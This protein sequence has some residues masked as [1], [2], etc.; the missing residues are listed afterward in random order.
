MAI[1]TC[2][3]NYQTAPI[4]IREQLAFNQDNIIVPLR[5]LI[6]R[7]YAR[8]AA[9]LSTCNRTEF[10]CDIDNALPIKEW[11]NQYSDIELNPYLY[12]YEERAAVRHILRVASGLDSMI[13]GEPQI[14]GQMKQA[15]AIAREAGTLGISLKRL[16]QHI[17]N[18][19]K[20]V[21]TNTAIGINSVSIASSAVNLSKRIFADLSKVTALLIGAGDTTSLAARYLYNQKIKH[22]II[23]NRTL[24]N[25]KALAEQFQGEAI[26][27]GDIPKYLVNADIIITATAS[28]LPIL[29]KGAIETALKVRKHRPMFM[30]DLA[31]PRDIEPEVANLKD[32]YLYTVDDLQNFVNDN[33]ENR[34]KAAEQAEQII[35][36]QA[37][38]YIRSLNLLDSVATICAFRENY[39]KIAQD[40]LQKVLKKLVNGGNP[41]EELMNELSRTLIN[42]LMHQPTIQMRKAAYNGQSEIL[43]L[44]KLLFDL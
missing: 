5:D 11:L 1:I 16:F 26:T 6:S 25:A 3:I 14:L 27:M 33:L 35:D 20:Q 7:G 40:E 18:V 39:E 15:V 24:D 19:T 23:A 4:A 28:P 30:V 13:L 32:V 41:P 12:F 31:V 29:G 2:G 38:H 36:F 44:A 9:I 8:E 34:Q 37:D 21:R 10:Y 43:N 17:F 42:K 22:L